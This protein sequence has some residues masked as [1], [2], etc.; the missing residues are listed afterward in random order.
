MKE[1]GK[2]VSLAQKLT[3]SQDNFWGGVYADLNLNDFKFTHYNAIVGYKFN[4]NFQL[5]AEQ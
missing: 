5:Y 1:K 3:Y 4:K 2:S